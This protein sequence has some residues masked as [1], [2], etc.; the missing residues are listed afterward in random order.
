[1]RNKDL[2]MKHRPY[3]VELIGP[4]GAGKTTILKALC[5]EN[6]NIV[7]APKPALKDIRNIL[8]F[9]GNAL[10]LLPVFFRQ[11]PKSKWL[12][13]RQMWWMIYLNGW[14]HVLGRKNSNGCSMKL[15]DH[16][17]MYMLTSLLKFGPEV[18]QSPYF[19]KWWDKMFKQW[20]SFLDM[21]I[22]LD[23]P[24]TILAE[25]INNRD[26]WHVVK[27]KPAEEVQ[28]F[29]VRYRTSLEEIISLSQSHNN[30]LKVLH[31]HTDRET[32]EQIMEKILRESQ[33]Q[34]KNVK[35]LAVDQ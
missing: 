33:M 4:A 5:R 14:H 15:I 1:M 20:A 29:L 24:N 3:I 30:C 13:W 7:K 21:V 34:S 32:P 18:T 17:P 25:R 9:I 26:T 11:R 31:F 2:K 12:S 35:S 22:W 23:A 27:E 16:G 28:N 10:P 19:R 8:F 6:K